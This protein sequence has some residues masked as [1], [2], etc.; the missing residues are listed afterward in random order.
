MKPLNQW[1]VLALLKT[2][3]TF[4]LTCAMYVTGNTAVGASIEKVLPDRLRGLNT[5]GP[6]H[7]LTTEETFHRFAE[8]GVNVV[9]VN[10]I[11]DNRIKPTDWEARVDVPSAMQP[12]RVGIARLDRMA[13]LALEYGI[14]LI[15]CADNLA[16]RNQRDVVE[17]N[18]E[19]RSNTRFADH[20]VGFWEFMA[21]RYRDNPAIIGYDLLNEPHTKLET[22]VWQK[23]LVPRL[24]RAI[25]E[26]DSET[27]I[28]FEPSPWGLPDA[29]ERGLTPLT[30]PRPGQPRILYSFHFYAPHNYTHQGI[31]GR[32]STGAYPGMLKMFPTSPTI[33]WDADQL[34]KYVRSAIAFKQRHTVRMF[35][36]EFG[37]TRWALGAATWVQDVTALLEAEGLDWAY[38]SYAGW[39][40]WNPT[41]SNDAPTNRQTD[42]GYESG[43]LKALKQYWMRNAIHE[44][45]RSHK[46]NIN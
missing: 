36:G 6:W 32:P 22:S 10:I 24:I 1:P 33:H 34:R 31:G 3:L 17:G 25:R 18:T 41:F 27:W 43:Q 13:E 29:Y 37:V 38:H 35:V 15:L 46:R 26:I 11:Q 5:Q 21:R 39:N 42:G 40:G 16:G 7:E 23:K 2:I 8:W 30:D 20:L 9:R 44:D 14:V 28:V 45:L 4:L 19:G 12:Y